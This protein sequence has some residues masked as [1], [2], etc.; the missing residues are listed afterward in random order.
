MISSIGNTNP[1][2]VNCSTQMS[3]AGGRYTIETLP[4]LFDYP[5]LGKIIYNP[6]G[7]LLS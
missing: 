2:S 7:T 6:N 1:Q 3:S 5:Q 4:V